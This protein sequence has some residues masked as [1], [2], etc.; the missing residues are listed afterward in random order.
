MGELGFAFSNGVSFF[1]DKETQAAWIDVS[2]RA[3][4]AL[5]A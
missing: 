5:L 2:G 3:D 4:S 1:A